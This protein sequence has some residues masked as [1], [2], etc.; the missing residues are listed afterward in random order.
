MSMKFIKI[1][2]FFTDVLSIQQQQEQYIT[3]TNVS[4][5]YKCCPGKYLIV[6]VYIIWKKCALTEV[7]E[8]IFYS[9]HWRQPDLVFQGAE[10]L[11]CGHG[12]IWMRC[13]SLETWL[14]CGESIPWRRKLIT[15]LRD[16]LCKSDQ[17]SNS[18]IQKLRTKSFHPF[19]FVLIL[20]LCCRLPR[21]ME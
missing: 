1:H 13:T 8:V 18:V 5:N 14:V 20:K 19:V 15:A 10:P 7:S 6:H 9:P 16:I 11:I 2:C 3:R 4:I 21:R 12:W 17:S